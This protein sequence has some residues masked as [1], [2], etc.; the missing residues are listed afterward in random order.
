MAAYKDRVASFVGMVVAI[1]DN[2]HPS[3]IQDALHG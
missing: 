1:Q 3:L 2:I